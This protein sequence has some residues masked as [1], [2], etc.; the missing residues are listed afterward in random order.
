[1][2]LRKI[3][4]R[5]Q[6]KDANGVTGKYRCYTGDKSGITDGHGYGARTY[7]DA[8]AEDGSVKSLG[9]HFYPELMAAMMLV[10]EGKRKVTVIEDNGVACVDLGMFATEPFR[11]I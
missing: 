2:L 7:T 9:E 8:I 3:D 4:I 10:L 1:M 11:P 5:Y 6:V